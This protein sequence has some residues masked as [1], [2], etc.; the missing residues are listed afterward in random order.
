MSPRHSRTPT[1]VCL[2]VMLTTTRYGRRIKQLRQDNAAFI[3]AKKV[4]A[5]EAI[6]LL[7][8]YATKRKEI[9]LASQGLVILEA[10][11]GLHRDAGRADALESRVIDVTSA[12]LHLLCCLFPSP[13]LL[14]L[15]TH[16]QL[17]QYLCKH[18]SHRRPHLLSS[19]HP[20]DPNPLSSDSMIRLP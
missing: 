13:R 15:L 2:C 9:E 17:S 18:S 16:T 10:T 4:E 5:Q 6:S 12:F 1:V 19:S 11:Y 7:T 3:E 8:D 20:R 14:K